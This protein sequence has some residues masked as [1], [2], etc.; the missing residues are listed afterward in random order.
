V[1]AV[2]TA[3]WS[4]SEPTARAK[5]LPFDA[6]VLV[7]SDGTTFWATV[8]ASR[9]SR[10]YQLVDGSWRDLGTFTAQGWWP[11]DAHRVLLDRSPA[12]L[13]TDHGLETTDLR[14]GVRISAVSRTS[15]GAFWVPGSGGRVFTSTDAVH[16]DSAS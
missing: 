12:P 7:R 13:L 14:A 16:W 6:D 10:M 3:R 5:S 11:L 15:D 2:R 4:P 8:P 1:K 9:G